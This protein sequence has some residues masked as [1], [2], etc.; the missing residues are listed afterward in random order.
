MFVDGKGRV[1]RARRSMK[2]WRVAFALKARSAIQVMPGFITRTRTRVG[3]RVALREEQA[4]RPGRDAASWDA[5]F[6]RGSQSAQSAFQESV[7]AALADTDAGSEP[8]GVGPGDAQEPQPEPAGPEPVASTAPAAV[9]PRTEPPDVGRPKPTPSRAFRKGV[10]LAALVARETPI[11]WFEAVAIVQEMC[12]V[13]LQQQGRRGG[14]PAEFELEDVAIT[15]D[16]NVEIRGAALQGLPT[17]PQVGHI[18]L[19]LLGEAQTLPVPLRLLAL[20]EVSPTPHC[21]T[22][23]ELS[24]QLGVFERPNRQAT[25]REVFE[26]Y[27]ALPARPVETAPAA[28]K[29]P[30][31]ALHQPRAARTPAWRSRPFRLAAAA[32]VVLAVSGAAAAVLWRSGGSLFW[33]ST[34]V[35]A[36]DSTGGESL[37]D[38]AVTRIREAALRIWGAEAPPRA[39]APAKGLPSP[40]AATEMPSAAPSGAVPTPGSTPVVSPGAAAV[41]P[42]SAALNVFSTSDADVEPPVLHRPHLPASPRPG[43]RVE[44][45]PQVEIVVSP[46][47]EVESVKLVTPSA[48]VHSAMMLSAIKTWHFQPASRDG[49]PVRYRLTLRL[50]NQ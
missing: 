27:M 21:S 48:G 38:D 17:V 25:I 42:A 33:R 26:R 2:P 47:G 20:Q 43:V 19:T 6:D 5:S 1:L 16:G 34:N 8:W 4:S 3:D 28:P 36:A 11:A 31:R 44:D 50:T 23:G 12:A 30:P 40:P 41:E 46:T 22:V 24:N 39:P 49:R 45:L 14:P 35:G 13:L 18:L 10:D 32:V 9:P 29:V 37:A 15:A 7:S